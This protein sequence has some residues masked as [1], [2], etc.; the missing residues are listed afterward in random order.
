MF[1]NITHVEFICI[2]M[3]Q[4]MTFIIQ[5]KGILKREVNKQ[6]QNVL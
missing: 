6:Q 5:K 3:Q 2:S 1:S 4:I